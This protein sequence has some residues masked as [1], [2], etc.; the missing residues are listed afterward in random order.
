MTG[1]LTAEGAKGTDDQEVGII[2]PLRSPRPLRFN[3]TWPSQV[4]AVWRRLQVI[5]KPLVWHRHRRLVLET[6]AG[7]PFVVLPEVFN[8]ALFSTSEFLVTYL[9]PETVPSGLVLDMGTG[10]GVGAVVAARW[11]RRVIAV[12]INPAA[13][14][15]VQINALLNHVDAKVEARL[16]D[17]FDPVRDE[18]FDL[19]LFNPP[20]FPGRPR[21]MYDHAWRSEDVIPRFLADLPTRLAPG[22]VALVVVSSA[23]DEDGL[24]AQAT[25]AGLHTT[26]VARRDLIYEID[27]IYKLRTL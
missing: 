4:R 15:C 1:F 25:Q 19:I 7:A 10:S 8:P 3:L 2:N 27:T 20:Y 6:V 12:D 5:R 9:G 24:I 11:A 18:V 26:I 17:L 16:G 22:G 23:V 13:V 21:D 14:R